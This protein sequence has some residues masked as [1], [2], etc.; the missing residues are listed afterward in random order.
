M[1]GEEIARQIFGDVWRGKWLA[2]RW[3]DLA[4]LNYGKESNGCQIYAV[5]CV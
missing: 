3:R 4:R 1:L 5:T 2:W